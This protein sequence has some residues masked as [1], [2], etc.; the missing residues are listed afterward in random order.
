M[1]HVDDLIEPRAEKILLPRLATLSWPHRIPR[2]NRICASESRIKF[3]RNPAPK[4]R[5]PA[6]PVTAKCR[7]RILNQRLGNSSRT[8]GSPGDAEH[9]PETR[10]DALLTMRSAE[11]PRLSQSLGTVDPPSPSARCI[12]TVSSQRPNL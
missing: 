1:L 2:Q 7:F 11:R 5:F 4:A 6:N 3:A 9:R 10:E 8:T 12:I